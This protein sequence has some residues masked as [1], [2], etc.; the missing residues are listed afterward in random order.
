[1]GLTGRLG[2][3]PVALCELRANGLQADID[4]VERVSFTSVLADTMFP[5]CLRPRRTYYG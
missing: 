2:Y 4:I 3:Y 1:M 5:D